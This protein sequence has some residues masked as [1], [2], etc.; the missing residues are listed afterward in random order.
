MMQQEYV[1]NVP[2]G[3]IACRVGNMN[4]HILGISPRSVVLRSFEPLPNHPITFYF[5]QSE[6]GNY[7]SRTLIDYETGKAQR[8]NGAV[9]SRFYFEDA[10]C[11]T[12]IRKSLN[13]YARYA[14]TRSTEGASAYGRDTTGYPL[15][16][17][18]IFPSSLEEARKTWFSQLPPLTPPRDCSLAVSLNCRELWELYLSMPFSGFMNAYASLRHVPCSVFPNRLPDRLYIGNEYCRLVMPGIDKLRALIAKAQAENLAVTLVTAEL[19][20]GEEA[21]ADALLSLAAEHKLEIEINDWGMLNRAQAF[22]KDIH[23]LFGTRL[24]KRRKDPRMQW[25]AG[26]SG[27]ESLLSRNALNDDFFLN[28]LKELGVVRFEYESCGLPAALEG[29]PGSL[30]LPFYQTN[31]SLWCPLNAL[32]SNGDRGRQVPADNCS[33]WCEENALL[34]PAHLGMLGRWNSLLAVDRELNYIDPGF[35]R[36]VLNF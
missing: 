13:S 29:I 31:T 8:E 7:I 15:E 20:A 36:W 28:F 32:C 21:H 26:I 34:Y 14:E 11:A 12:L 6:I 10:A 23:I 1:E 18:D 30:H 19:R 24:N 16:L 3:L 17:D 25:K 22:K 2:S 9:L 33:R 35:D 27:Q 4:V 5:Y